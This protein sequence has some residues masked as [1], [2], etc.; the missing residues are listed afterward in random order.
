MWASPADD[1]CGGW[2]KS[3]FG[4]SVKPGL[5]TGLDSPKQLYTDSKRHQGYNSLSP[6]LPQFAS[7][8]LSPRGIVFSISE[9]SKVTYNNLKQRWLWLTSYGF[10]KWFWASMTCIYCFIWRPHTSVGKAPSSIFHWALV[11]MLC[12]LEG[13]EEQLFW[14]ETTFQPLWKY[15]K[16]K[17]HSSV[18]R[19]GSKLRQSWRQAAVALVAFAVCFGQSSQVQCSP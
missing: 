5:W 2:R 7:L 12:I 3:L 18:N 16:Q 14:I 9:R 4:I 10:C 8:L 1:S 19:Q 13:L 17:E 6:A 11:R 15:R